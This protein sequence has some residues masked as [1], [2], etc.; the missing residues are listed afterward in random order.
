M[1]Q[2]LI[3]T[4]N[5][6]GIDPDELTATQA[7]I[8]EG[9][10]AGMKGNDEPVF[11]T[12]PNRGAWASKIGINGKVT[13]PEGY[14]NGNGYMDQS[15]N[16]R[17]AISYSLPINGSYTVPEGYHNG[18]GKV[19]QSIA[20]MGSQT[21]T[22]SSSQ[23]TIA[24]NGK[25]MT[26]NVVVTPSPWNTKFIWV[27]KSEDHQIIFNTLPSQTDKIFIGATATYMGI[28]FTV[29]GKRIDNKSG[30]D[31]GFLFI[32]ENTPLALFSDP[33]P[34]SG[35]TSPSSAI[36][37]YGG[38]DSNNF[39]IRFAGADWANIYSGITIYILGYL[40]K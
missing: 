19:T 40:K 3:M 6:G 33:H 10:K 9:Y 37:I 32:T 36:H 11:G 14:H 29:K 22:P 18:S 27:G 4:G 5:N 2:C 24:C 17:G 34:S 23:Q 20:T 16:N 13:I 38:V 28:L 21:I 25:Y 26:G 35:S 8:L 12:M 1:G 7:Q 31:L 15:I 30:F 39:Y